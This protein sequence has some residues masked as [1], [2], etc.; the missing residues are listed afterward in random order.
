MLTPGNHKLGGSRI[1]GFSLPSGRPSVCVG[2]SPACRADCYAAALERYRPAAARRYRANLRLSRRPDFARRV[3][4]F[5]VAHAVRVV[6]VHVGGDFYSAAYA[7]KWLRVMRASPR[8]L[9]Y[10]YTRSWR[11][12]EVKRVIDEMAGLPNC[13]AW[14]S[15]DRDTG[16][17]PEMPPRARVAWLMTSPDDL[18]PPG[19][20]LVFR[21]RR[22]RRGPAPAAAPAC[23]AEDGVPRPRAA[24]CDRCGFCWRPAPG[25]R[26]PLPVLAPEPPGRCP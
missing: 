3:R 25:G 16:L 5:L 8:V 22:L 14:Y 19:T 10:F 9:F 15:A 6:R 20:G 12:P 26:F 7:G 1:W 24:T 17:P 23:P 2:M 18:P 4:A 11:V 21:V 13:R